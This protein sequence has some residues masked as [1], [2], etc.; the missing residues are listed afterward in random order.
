M[1]IVL[2]TETEIAMLL[3][4]VNLFCSVEKATF[5]GLHSCSKPTKTA[6]FVKAT[7]ISKESQRNRR[8][9][10]ESEKEEVHVPSLH[11]EPR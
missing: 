8:K 4:A 3:C 1:E 2:C 11:V 6:K 9:K 10:V 7:S 5:Y